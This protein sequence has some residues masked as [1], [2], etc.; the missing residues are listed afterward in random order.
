MEVKFLNI[1][2]RFSG[3]IFSLKNKLIKAKGWYRV[4]PIALLLIFVEIIFTLISLPLFFLVPPKS[5]QEKGFIFP[6]KEQ[7]QFQNYVIRRKITL[8]TTVGAGGIFALKVLVVSIFSFYLL[9]VQTLLADTQDWTFDNSGDF[10]FDSAKIEVTGGVA[11]LKDTGS[12][13]SGATS[14]PDFNTN[15]TGWT[16]ADWDQGGGEVNVTGARVT[17]GGNPGGW[18]NINV[19]AGKGDQV[20]GYWYQAFTTTVADPTVLINFDYQ[21][22]AFDSTPAPITFKLFVGTDAGFAAPVIGQEVW[23]SGEITSTQGWTSVTN[24]DASSK[25]TVA[26]TYYFKLSAWI[27]TPG[28]NTG[29]F[30]VGFDNASLNWNKTTHIYA[31]DR[32]TIYPNASLNPAKALTWDSFTETATKNGGEI[33]YQLSDDDGASWKYWDGSAWVVAGASNYN[34]ASIVN[35]NISAFPTVTNKIKWK[36]FLEGNG[37]QQV[38]LDNIS[39]GYTQNSLPVVASVTPVQNTAAGYVYVNYNLQDN[40]SDPLSLT[41]YEYSLTGAFAGEQAT[42]S[43]VLAD[44]EHDGVSGLSASPG[45]VAH[46]FVW[47]AKSQIGTIYDSTVYVRLRANDGVGDSPNTTSGA[48]AVDYALPVVTNVSAM[49][50]LGTTDVVFTYDLADD[51]TTDALVEVDIS[52]DGGLTWNVTDVSVSGAVGTG[53]ATGVG[54]TITWLAKTDFTDQVQSDLQVRV[55]ARDKWQNQGLDVA[56]ANFALDTLS[57]AT[58]TLVNLQAQPNA[59]DTVALLGGSFTETNPNT[60]DFYLAINDGAYSGATVGTADTA[61]PANQNTAVGAT[62]DGNDYISKVKI[63]H[64]DDFGQT[65]DNENTSPATIYKFVKPYTPS[66]PT[67][68]SPATTNL[69]LTINPHGSEAGDLQYAMVETTTNKYVQSDGTLGDLAYWR[70]SGTVNV[71]GLS[72]PLSQ[73]IFKVKSR[74]PND[75]A[76]ADSSESSFSATSQITNTAPAVTYGVIAQTVDGTQYVT[77]NYT[78][79]DG[80]GDICSLPVYEYSTNN[81]DWFTMTEKS[82]VGSEGVS[83]LIFLSGGSAHNFVWD[84][85]TDLPNSEYGSVKVRVRPNDSLIDGALATSSTFAVDQKAP[86]IS[87]VSASQDVGA[88]TVTVGY[89]L[90]DAHS[91]L[92]EIDISEDGGFS[93]TVADSSVSGAVGAGVAPGVGKSITWNAGADF[94]GQY[95]SDLRVRLRALDTFGNQGGNVESGNFTLDT[96]DPVI[97]NLSA[98]QDS[99][100]KTFTFNYD[101]AEDAGNTDVAIVISSNS[102]SSWVVPV[103][104]L[105]GDVGVGIVPGVGQTVT[106]DAGVDYDGFEKSTMKFRVTATDSFANSGVTASGDFSLDT[107]APRVTDV[108]AT[109]TLGTTNVAITYTLADQNNSLVEID[110]SEDAGFSW[111]VADTAVTGDIGAGVA[112][113]S[114]SI[115]W[116][117]GIDFDSQDQSDLRVRVRAKDIFEN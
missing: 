56:S 92:V 1:F 104:S 25:V 52:E 105:L 44:P 57:P 103:T 61:T 64:T 9:G 34:T 35:S 97:T 93:W 5:I 87:N 83:N 22:S 43:P 117:A 21:V 68:S 114:K 80:Q 51:T 54:K 38:I 42:M 20:G 88:G 6:G 50:T 36:A 58:A 32:P 77:V 85:G 16:Y 8:A 47:D 60:N 26:G 10:T 29:P 102:G 75:G 82:G 62:L 107:L 30:T 91:S 67:L 17:S 89:D 48:F 100:A 13:V 12:V 23:S 3:W 79:T 72:S 73:Y 95:Q 46:T 86:I 40:N 63:T 70:S 45:G 28:T 37:T 18:I 69:N 11:Q 98:A 49:Q 111:T 112:G 81:V 59:G 113:G 19:P 90:S 14:N 108:S 94:D 116:S 15:I 84:S 99:A 41:A 71:N 53:V 24:V 7:K 76:H 78:G 39:I 33:Y 66:A 110:I 96:H 55:R 31:S 74:N 27:E 101:L 115:T 4:L 106:W 65:G 2:L 109:Q